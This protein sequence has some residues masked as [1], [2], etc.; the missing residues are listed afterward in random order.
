M[1]MVLSNMFQACRKGNHNY[2]EK[3]RERL[4]LK[5][6]QTSRDNKGNTPL[7]VAVANK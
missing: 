4:P 2:I 7:Y 1:Q 5:L 3:N 6:L